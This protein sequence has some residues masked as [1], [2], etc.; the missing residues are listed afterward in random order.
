MNMYFFII[1]IINSCI[2]CVV[3]TTH[4]LVVWESDANRVVEVTV[5]LKMFIQ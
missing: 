5:W 1:V 2:T 3:F 4:A